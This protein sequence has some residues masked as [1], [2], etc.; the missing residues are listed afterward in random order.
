MKFD[1]SDKGMREAVKGMRKDEKM[2]TLFTGSPHT[3]LIRLL[4]ADKL[5]DYPNQ[6]FK[7]YPENKLNELADD[8][9]VNG[10]LSPLRVRPYEDGF[11][12][13][14]GHNRRNAAVLVGM[15]EVPCIITEDIDDDTAALIVVNTNLNQRDELLPSEKAYAY[16]MQLE[17]MKRRAGRPS[18]ND[19][20]FEQDLRNITSRDLLSEKTGDSASKIQRYIRLTWLIPEFLQMVDDKV[21]PFMVGVSLSYHHKTIQQKILDFM[22]AH[23][24]NKITLQQASELS[25]RANLTEDVLSGIF[26]LLDK[27][28]KLEKKIGRTTI[29]KLNSYFSE[30]EYD[31]KE[32]A[33]IIELALSLWEEKQQQKKEA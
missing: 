12:I 33:E 18:K 4:P 32:I 27:E 10:I 3:E 31:D 17:A 30:S 20:Q 9:E 16:K 26:G 2:L 23:E 22:N 8:I 24:I 7:P 5:Y 15:K 14:A 25:K 29:K 28:P 1:Y 11:Q 6:P 13:L 19:V 21:L